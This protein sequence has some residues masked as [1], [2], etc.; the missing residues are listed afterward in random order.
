MGTDRVA[1]LENQIS[2][3]KKQLIIE[4]EKQAVAE[5]SGLW[6]Y[7]VAGLYERETATKMIEKKLFES[8]DEPGAL[9]LVDLNDFKVINDTY[10]R[11]YSDTVLE[12]A[13]NIISTSFRM[14]DIVGR[15]A[16]D[17]FFIFCSG[18]ENETAAE[19]LVNKM[20]ERGIEYERSAKVLD[21]SFMT[22]LTGIG[23]YLERYID[24]S[25]PSVLAFETM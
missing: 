9:L 11:V 23:Y 6:E 18:I 19:K 7:D 21:I 2:E 5:D 8:P 24:D 13:S 1:E 22:G 25:I 4:K 15:I 12:A 10:G 20:L 14:K 17:A 3:L 16:G